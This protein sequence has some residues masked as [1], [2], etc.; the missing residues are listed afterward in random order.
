MIYLASR[1]AEPT[2]TTLGRKHFVVF[3]RKAT[4]TTD[5][6]ELV[7]AAAMCGGREVS[8]HSFS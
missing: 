5:F 7:G 1:R 6:E 8:T 3:R 4:T 2:S